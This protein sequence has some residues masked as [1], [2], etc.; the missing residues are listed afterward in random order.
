MF[1]Q[2]AGALLAKAT[3]LARIAFGRSEPHHV[4]GQAASVSRALVLPSEP[5]PVA[6]EAVVAAQLAGLHSSAQGLSSAEASA[7]LERYGPNAIEEKEPSRWAKLVGLSVGTDPLDDRG[8]GPHFPAPPGLAGLRRGHRPAGLQRRHRLLA[9]R[10]G[11][12]RP[13]RAQE[14]PGAQGA[15]PARRRMDRRRRRRPSSPATW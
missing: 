2:T 1:K 11:G 13:G 8:R 5:P 14:E 7:R 9:G 15:G 10:Q 6:V 12:Q 4:A 3:P